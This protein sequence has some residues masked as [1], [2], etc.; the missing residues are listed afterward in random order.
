MKKQSLFS[1]IELFVYLND[2]DISFEMNPT[3]TEKL[4]S[5]TL[6]FIEPRLASLIKAYLQGAGVEATVLTEPR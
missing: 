2:E 5:E 4:A 6:T 1:R 3:D